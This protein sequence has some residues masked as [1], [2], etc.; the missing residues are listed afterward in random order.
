MPDLLTAVKILTGS[1]VEIAAASVAEK[2]RMKV[3]QQTEGNGKELGATVEVLQPDILQAAANLVADVADTVL[4]DAIEEEVADTNK[5]EEVIGEETSAFAEAEKEEPAASPPGEAAASTL[6]EVAEADDQAAEDPEAATEEI[7]SS[8]EAS[9]ETTSP[10]EDAE[11]TNTAE[12]PPVIDTSPAPMTSM[13]GV[14]AP[15]A[16]TS[17]AAAVVDTSQLAAASTLSHPKL[18]SDAQP[19]APV[20][21]VRPSHSCHCAPAAAEEAAPPAA[22]GGELLS[23]GAVDVNHEAK[24]AMDG[25]SKNVYSGDID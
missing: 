25:Q 7:L 22:A 2:S 17:E 12:A 1:S 20:D 14:E 9:S 23:E 6:K 10:S 15:A 4:K 16:E 11:G 19:E 24:K 18:L 3:V 21:E 13:E 5:A 8:K